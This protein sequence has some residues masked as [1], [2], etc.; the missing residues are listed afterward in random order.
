MINL[1]HVT[2]AFKTRSGTVTAIHD[3]SAAIKDGSMTAIVGKSGSGKSTLLGLLGTLDKPTYG[4]V[5]V[6]RRKLETMSLR[7]LTHYRCEHIGF[8]FQQF[9]LLADISALENVLVPMEFARLPRSKR[10]TRAIDLLNQ[11][12]IT[13]TKQSRRPNRLSG[14][15]QQRVAIARALANNPKLILADEPTGNLDSETGAQIMQ[16]LRRMNKQLGTS[17]IIV[18]HDRSIARQCDSILTIVD[19]EVQ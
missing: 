9:N 14:G 18:T 8:V 15:E 19:G 11:V 2:K 1:E 3:A 12:G 13:G 10:K 6:D 17:I 16:T 4:S 7:Q 5:I